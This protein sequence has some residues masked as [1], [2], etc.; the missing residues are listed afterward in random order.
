MILQHPKEYKRKTIGTVP[1]IKLVL[2]KRCQVIVSPKQGQEMGDWFCQH[3]T[4]L[5][6]TKSG[7]APP[8]PHPSWSFCVHAPC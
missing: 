1:L 6:A 7:G 8:L 2:G 5:E 3:P 4:V